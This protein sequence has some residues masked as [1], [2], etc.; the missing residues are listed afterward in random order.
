VAQHFRQ[1][2]SVMIGGLYLTNQG[3]SRDGLLLYVKEKVAPLAS[4]VGSFP[5]TVRSRDHGDDLYISVI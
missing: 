1:H 4:S 3:P 5:D 2:N